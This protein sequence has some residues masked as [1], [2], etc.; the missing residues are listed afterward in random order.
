MVTPGQMLRCD[1]GHSWLKLIAAT[2]LEFT[3]NFEPRVPSDGITH[4]LPGVFPCKAL[5]TPKG[6]R[7]F[8]ANRGS[9]VQR[10]SV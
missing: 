7:S 5:H 8:R 10:S 4:F 9:R 1:S 6:E 3:C 2:L